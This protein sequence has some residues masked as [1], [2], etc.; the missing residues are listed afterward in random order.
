MST[1]LM[2]LIWYTGA[3]VSCVFRGGTCLLLLMLLL[4]AS[5]PPADHCL[6][7]RV[8]NGSREQYAPEMQK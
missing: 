1:E 3:Q 8:T 6:A 4:L 5:A 2:Q 7:C